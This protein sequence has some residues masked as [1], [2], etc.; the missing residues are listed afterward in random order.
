MPKP[1]QTEPAKP[2]PEAVL[3]DLCDLAESA[4]E[5]TGWDAWSIIDGKN[6]TLTVH[7]EFPKL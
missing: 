1:K 3:C 2:I 6:N 7:V 5:E 4:I